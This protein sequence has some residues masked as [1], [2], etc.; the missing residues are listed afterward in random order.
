MSFHGEEPQ[1]DEIPQP[2][3]SLQLQPDHGE[4]PQPN[5]QLQPEELPQN[6]HLNQKNRLSLVNCDIE[7]PGDEARQ[8]LAIEHVPSLHVG[9]IHLAIGIS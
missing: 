8:S 9:A 5:E 3:E 6:N 7:L 2:V 4:E 1:P